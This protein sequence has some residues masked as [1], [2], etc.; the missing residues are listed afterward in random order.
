MGGF[1]WNREFWLRIRNL[2]G[3][4]LESSEVKSRIRLAL[5]PYH[6]PGLK[7]WSGK[8]LFLGVYVRLKREERR[9]GEL[10]LSTG[11]HARARSCDADVTTGMYLVDRVSGTSHPVRRDLPGILPNQTNCI[12]FCV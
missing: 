2:V 3:F 9:S 4:F 8:Q 11:C 5:L 6:V 7:T 10:E 12:T 1:V